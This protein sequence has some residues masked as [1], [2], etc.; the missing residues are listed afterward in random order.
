[1]TTEAAVTK[2]MWALGQTADPCEVERILLTPLCGELSRGDRGAAPD[3][4]RGGSA[5]PA[6]RR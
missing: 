6:P 1:M 4:G 3:P 5:S 2:L